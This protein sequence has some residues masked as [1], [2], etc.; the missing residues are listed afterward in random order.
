[1]HLALRKNLNQF[2]NSFLPCCII[3][4]CNNDLLKLIHKLIVVLN[5]LV[6]TRSP[7]SATNHRNRIKLLI[8]VIIVQNL[9]CCKHVIFSSY[10]KEDSTMSF[11]TKLSEKVY[12]LSDSPIWCL[13]ALRV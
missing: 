13:E 8:L 4:H 12:I 9:I 6:S 3:V 2:P 7:N 10:N 11:E 5:L 1:M